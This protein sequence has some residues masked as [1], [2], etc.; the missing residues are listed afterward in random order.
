MRVLEEDGCGGSVAVDGAA[1]VDAWVVVVVVSVVAAAAAASA[2]A[3]A[4]CCLSFEL[5]QVRHRE[6]TA[7][8]E[9]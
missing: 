6:T 9:L 3:F 1:D 5:Q 2:A 8:V 7:R 4:A